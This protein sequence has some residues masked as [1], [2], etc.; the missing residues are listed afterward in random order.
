M[1]QTINSGEFA[2]G[3]S[4][5]GTIDGSNATYTTSKKFV[6]GKVSVYLNGLKQKIV[7]EF[8][9]TGNQTVIFTESPQ[10]GDILSVD[11][12]IY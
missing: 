4:L 1:I 5:I 8:N 10:S 9:T 6:A 3:E 11:Y 12:E 7:N 2:F